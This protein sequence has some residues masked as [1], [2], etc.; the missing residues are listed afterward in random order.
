VGAHPRRV[1][2][3]GQRRLPGQLALSERQAV[4]ISRLVSR[5]EG[6]GRTDPS[7][8]CPTEVR[9][10]DLLA[11]YGGEEFVLLLPACALHDAVRI[12]ERLRVVTP[13]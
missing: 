13:W 7:P 5:L 2:A 8:G 6:L 9:S 11:R 10:T 3:R 1:R 12:V 4:E